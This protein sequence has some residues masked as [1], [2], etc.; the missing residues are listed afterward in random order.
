MENE[1]KHVLRFLKQHED[2]AFFLTEVV[3]ALKNRG[4]GAKHV[5]RAS[6]E[7]EKRGLI[8]VGTTWA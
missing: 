4:I 3:E 7:Y 6:R 2:E 5:W 1:H 8:K